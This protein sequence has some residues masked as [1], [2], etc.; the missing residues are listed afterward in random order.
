MCRGNNGHHHS[1]DLHLL[2][3]S[4]LTVLSPGALTACGD[5]A[6]EATPEPLTL[7]VDRTLTGSGHEIRVDSA[8]FAPRYSWR[9]GPDIEHGPAILVSVR[10][11]NQSFSS[12]AF[13]LYNLYLRHPE[14]AGAS[15]PLPFDFEALPPGESSSV[16]IV[17]PLEEGHSPAD[18]GGFALAMGSNSRERHEPYVRFD[19]APSPDGT[20]IQVPAGTRIQGTL[21]FE[22]TRAELRTDYLCA[23][24]QT[25]V[26]A[27]ELHIFATVTVP[28]SAPED[29]E[30]LGDLF[31][32]LEVHDERGSPY[33][34][35]RGPGACLPADF[36]LKRPMVQENVVF[37]LAVGEQT[38]QP[39]ILTLRYAGAEGTL[40]IPPRVP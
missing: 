8:T 27:R 30:T 33:H 36:E 31:S 1:H 13:A 18:L 28:A 25:S 34:V 20:P 9:D 2:L 5:D 11:R 10:V 38:D 19:G 17:F 35:V 7:S 21:G 12:S 22:V 37:Y 4:V 26:G 39:R 40:V 14:G 32:F 29:P 15:S 24:E 3:L 16:E 6:Q 23:F